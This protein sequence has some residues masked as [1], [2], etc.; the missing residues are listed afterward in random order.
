MTK[1]DILKNMKKKLLISSLILGAAGTGFNTVEA[2]EGTSI[3]TEE[4]KE[5]K[6]LSDYISYYSQ[7]YGIKERYIY[8]LLDYETNAYTDFEDGMELTVLNTT[9]DLY[10]NPEDYGL[11]DEKVRFERDYD[12]TME[13]EEAV[14]KYA[15]L[16]G[17]SKEIALSIIYC[18]CGSDVDSENY[19][20]NNNPAGLGPYMYFE[21]KEIGVIYFI[22]L[23]K[24]DYG[25][26]KDSDEEFLYGMANTYSGGYSDIWLSLTV[27]FY[28]YLTDDYYY[29][30]PELKE[31]K[32]E[33]KYKKELN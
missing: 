32:E 19:R 8:D 20:D 31:K 16:F 30:K 18:E 33:K 10:Y 13:I 4:K 7:V 26:T 12:M 22:D 5:E 3:V 2:K 24:Y 27:P 11:E 1:K 25:C 14:E 9:R 29:K 17:I 21:N 6:S 28:N 15:N 23:L